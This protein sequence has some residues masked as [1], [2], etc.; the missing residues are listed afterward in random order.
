MGHRSPLI[1]WN[2]TLIAYLL[3]I[4]SPTHPV[5]ASLYYSGWASQSERARLYRQNWGKT[6][7]GDLYRNGSTYYGIDLPV[8]VGPGG[9]LF[10]TH[11]PFL[12]SIRGQA[13]PVRDCSRMPPDT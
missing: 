2:E 13:R 5:P 10:F 12:G 3:A 7:A 4:A 9:P 8:G 1:G 6:T 11:Y